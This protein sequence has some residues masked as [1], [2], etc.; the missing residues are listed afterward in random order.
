MGLE[1]Q[2]NSFLKAEKTIRQRVRWATKNRTD[3]AELSANV[4]LAEGRTWVRGK[5]KV[6]AHRTM[7]PPKYGF[8]LL[9]RGE[10]VLALDVNPNRS[11]RNLLTRKSVS[12]THWQRYPLMEAEVDHR[13]LNFSAWV[14][15]F[16]REANIQ[17]RYRV[18]APPVGQQLELELKSW[19]R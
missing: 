9:F 7:L 12:S 17:L 18:N 4:S 1:D 3:H 16:M 14:D 13:I 2:I 8:S 5:L 10:R 11:H 6:V 15:E 19:K